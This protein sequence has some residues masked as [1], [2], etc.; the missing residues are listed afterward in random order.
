MV[1]PLLG[2]LVRGHADAIRNDI[3]K[4]FVIVDFR[5]FELFES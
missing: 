5:Q 2:R 4:D 1:G 3:R